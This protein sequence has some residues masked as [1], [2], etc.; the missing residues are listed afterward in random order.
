M[1]VSAVWWSLCLPFEMSRVGIPAKAWVC[2]RFCQCK[3]RDVMV[4]F[5]LLHQ[6]SQLLKGLRLFLWCQLNNTFILLRLID[7]KQVYAKICLLFHIENEQ[8]IHIINLSTS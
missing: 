3:I 1:R 8:L 6:V 5:F 7:T 4:K 2:L